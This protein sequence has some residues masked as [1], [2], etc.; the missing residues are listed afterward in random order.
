MKT[1]VI[2][3]L[4]FLA[5][6][7]S[8]SAGPINY[9][10]NF[11]TGGTGTFVYDD[12]AKTT[13]SITLRFGINGNIPPYGF[14][15][16]TTANVFG[17]PPTPA[18]KQNN[19]FFGATSTGARLRV[20]TDGT[21]CL[22]AT[23]AETLPCL[24]AGTYNIAPYVPP[25][26]S[27]SG[28]YALNFSSGG[29]SY[30]TYDAVNRRI[31]VF[32]LNFGSFGSI[33]TDFNNTPS[34]TNI[35][36]APVLGSSLIQDNTFLPLSGGSASSVRL[37][38]NGT[39]CIRPDGG[40]CGAGD[41]YSGT[42]NIALAT[43]PASGTYAFNFSTGGSGTYI[44]DSS[45]GAIT[46]LAASF[47]SFGSVSTTVTATNT[48]NAFGVLLGSTV[49]QDTS[50][51]LTGGSA[52]AFRL[53]S[54]GTFCVRLDAGACG[55]GD[56]VSG[57]YNIT[58]YVPP[59]PS[60]SGTYAFNFSTGGSGYFNYD[61]AAQSVTLITYEFGTFGRW[62]STDWDPS[63]TEAV[64]GLPLGT[65]VKLE[66]AFFGLAGGSA[67]GA[68]L[69]PDGIFCVRAN[70]GVCGDGPDLL[71]GTYSIALAE[72]GV[73]DPG[74]NVVAVPE[75]TDE[76]GNPVE[77]GVVLTFESVQDAGDI[78][79]VV[80]SAASVEAPSGF[81]VAGANAAF[82]LTTT[83]TF[84]GGVQVCVPYDE[85]LSNELA[86]R[87]LHFHGGVWSDITEADSPDTVNNRIC[88]S[89]DSFSLFAVASDVAPPTANPTA[90][91]TA[92]P[93]GWNNTDVTVTWHW[94]DNA[95][96]SALDPLTCPTS[97]TSSGEGSALALSA[98]CQDR[99]GNVA[100]TASYVA[101]IDKTKPTLSPWVTPSS[102]FLNGT[103]AA[104]SGAADE[105][106]GLAAE[107][108]GALNTT[109]PGIKT[110]ICTATDKAGNSNSASTTYAVNYN[111]SGFFAPVNDAP[112][113][114]TGKAG[115][116]YPVKWQLRDG[117]SAYISS[118]GAVTSI[119]YKAT[120]CSEFSGDATDALE[121][122]TTG[123]T[124]LRYDA[125][126]N[127]YVYNWATP[128]LGCYT[129]FVKLNS[130]QLLSAYF[131]LSK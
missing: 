21:F 8:A 85:T 41:L 31:P 90:S 96:A 104:T 68:R 40:A 110:V 27:P 128:G 84:A 28:T 109:T 129:L 93:A 51:N 74:E 33:S 16:T 108:C 23:S 63:A 87:L 76:G 62:S 99:A 126:S 115:R 94:T 91:P 100:P 124:S 77:T 125:G 45:S 69:Q 83:G 30:F 120:S 6:A 112:V 42:Y 48:R 50:F 58:P 55:A 88:G 107:S 37:R 13:S 29:T 70:T 127:Q 103:A 24:I 65:A 121:T 47:G 5:L 97:S 19:T 10:F 11:S 56:L 95:G 79:L 61:A 71:S 15:S 81:Q 73:I 26:N 131:N 17:A 101:A 39:F 60:V 53:R 123:S 75:A 119:A 111:F 49:F 98:A 20:F 35:F 130:G 52:V 2:R 4:V 12:V 82:D 57:T 92:N 114:N 38:A 7:G 105:L 25:P 67:Y 14:D 22:Y 72:P 44:Y 89:T 43:L 117:N 102:I 78:S 3:L 32:R 9:N 64:F 36:G 18:V 34:A 122:S 46:A 54:N 118:L 116:T 106:S 59:Q 1:V 113:V 66:N 86:L 80:Q